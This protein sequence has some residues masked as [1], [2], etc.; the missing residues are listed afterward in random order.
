M[1]DEKPKPDMHLFD[2]AVDIGS[3]D[4][5][6]FQIQAAYYSRAQLDGSLYEFKD[7]NAK[8]VLAVPH[9][10]VLYI[11]RKEG[12]VGRMAVNTFAT[13]GLVRGGR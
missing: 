13:G 10:R 11:H 9:D 5:K 8:V 2:V 7:D 1:A 4:A 6:Q 3:G 12:P